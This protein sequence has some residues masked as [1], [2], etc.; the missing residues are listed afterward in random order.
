MFQNFPMWNFQ[1]FL[2]YWLFL[3]SSFKKNNHTAVQ[4]KIRWKWRF[5]LPCVLPCF[6][7]LGNKVDVC[8]QSRNQFIM[9]TFETVPSTQ[10]YR[11][12]SWEG[13]KFKNIKCNTSS[14]A[15]PNI[16]EIILKKSRVF[17]FYYI[18]LCKYIYLVWLY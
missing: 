4:K 8:I 3:L 6:M 2:F 9:K 16:L 5:C 13:E 7:I 10:I 1:K 11:E 14:I 18:H 15:K 17:I 12:G